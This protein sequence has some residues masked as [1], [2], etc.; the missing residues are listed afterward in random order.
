MTTEEIPH[1]CGVIFF[2][3]GEV[4]GAE[5]LEVCVDGGLVRFVT[6]PDSLLVIYGISVLINFASFLS[7]SL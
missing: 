5:E 3:G 2:F 4:A 6:K 1:W 7:P